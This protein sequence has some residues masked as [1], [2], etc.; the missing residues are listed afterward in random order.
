MNTLRLCF[1]LLHFSVFFNVSSAEPFSLLVGA[2]TTAIIAGLYGSYSYTKCFLYEC[3]I[4]PWIEPNIS[5]MRAIMKDTFYGQH[6]AQQT[7]P[8]AIQAHLANENPSKALVMSFHG[9]TG[10]GKNFLS[11]II[12]NNIYKKGA[13]S[14]YVNTFVAT[15]HFPHKEYLATYQDQLRSWIVGNLSNCPHALFI[16]DEVDKLPVKLLDTVK[17]FMDHYS[18]IH[19]VD[20]RKSVFIFLSNAGSEEIARRAWEYYDAGKPRESITLKEMEEMLSLEAFNQGGLKT[21]ELISSHMIDHFVPFFPLERRHVIECARDYLK[22]QT[23]R[24]TSRQLEQIAE[25]LTY[26]PKE[27]PVFS[28]SGCRNVDKK[29]DLIM[30]VEDDG[31][32]I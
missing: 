3:C 15:T 30:Q 25:S 29:S 27:N 31:D 23:I 11:R 26:F 20:P 2:G 18:N 7:V 4:N 13:K 16:F 24:A 17:P 1:I 5:G 19:G 14:Q 9:W 21:S 8:T 12:A 32:L 22:T 10:S 6:L 28:A